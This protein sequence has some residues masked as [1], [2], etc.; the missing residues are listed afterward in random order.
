MAQKTY[1][2]AKED[3]NKF[4]SLS[5]CFS[6]VI[7]FLPGTPSVSV[8][9]FCFA[10]RGEDTPSQPLWVLLL[11]EQR[12]CYQVLDAWGCRRERFYSRSTIKAE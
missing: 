7:V 9:P 6:I 12:A 8:Q 2:R 4:G 1:E 3:E 5:L 10:G 11:V